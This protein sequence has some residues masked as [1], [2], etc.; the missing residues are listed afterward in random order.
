[1]LFHKVHHRHYG[2]MDIS[3]LFSKD[4]D[5]WDKEKYTKNDCETIYEEFVKN[6]D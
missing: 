4:L 1:M 6:I 3:K 5:T 2:I